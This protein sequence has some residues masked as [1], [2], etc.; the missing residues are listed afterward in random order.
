MRKPRMGGGSRNAGAASGEDDTGGLS[1]LAELLGVTVRADSAATPEGEER[2][3]AA[4]RAARDA[5]ASTAG[6]RL[7]GGRLRG[8]RRPRRT[9]LPVR[10]A[11]G[12]LLASVMLGGVAAASMGAFSGST[13]DRP[14]PSRT[15]PAH[16]VPPSD[17]P[18]LPARPT[19][20][21]LRPP[22][23]S[24]D[25]PRTPDGPG[26]PSHHDRPKPQPKPKPGPGAKESKPPKPQQEKKTPPK[27][28]HGKAKPPQPHREKAPHAPKANK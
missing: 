25:A 11:L 27:P 15:A 3:V 19:V 17:R 7:W 2:A 14:A 4:F 8:S 21:L 9:G 26:K 24:P 28:H 10:A 16:A 13:P 20:P 18:T 23:A 22:D 12:T 5:R 1:E 6:A